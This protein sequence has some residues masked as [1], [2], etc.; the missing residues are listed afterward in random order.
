MVCLQAKQFLPKNKALLSTGYSVDAKSYP[1]ERVLYLV[2]YTRP[3]RSQGLV[4]SILLGGSDALTTFH[5][6]NNAEFVRTRKADADFKKEGIKFIEPPL[7]GIWTQEH[8]AAAI[9]QIARGQTSDFPL[10]YPS[11]I[12]EPNRCE[13]Y[14]DAFNK[15]KQSN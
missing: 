5:V 3:N 10:G 13:S 2:I 11:R 6:V 8:I 15:Q 1:G 9:D 12:L 4:F 7:W 14:V